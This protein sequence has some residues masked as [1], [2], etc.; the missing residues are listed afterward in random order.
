M[1]AREAQGARDLCGLL[2]EKGVLD[3]AEARECREESEVAMG[4][5]QAE[6][7]AGVLYRFGEGLQLRDRDGRIEVLVGNRIQGR[8]TY[9]DPVGG[10][11][12]SAFAVRRFKTF[13]RGAFYR[14]WLHFKLQVNWVGARAANGERLPDL[15]DALLEVA[16]W[17]AAAVGAGQFKVPFNR[18]ELT[19]SGAQQFVDRAITNDR[20]A[21]DRDQGVTVHGK[22]VGQNGAAVEYAVAVL[23]GS[24]KNRANNRTEPLVAGRAQWLPLGPLAYSESDVAFTETARLALGVAFARQPVQLSSDARRPALMRLTADAHFQWRGLSVAGDLFLEEPE[25][26]GRAGTPGAL[27]QAGWFLVPGRLEVAGRYAVYNPPGEK[28]RR[29]EARGGINWFFSGHSLKLQVDAGAVT[30]EEVGASR[31][32]STDARLQV[33]VIF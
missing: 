22:L 15:E 13:A 9:A 7:S 21:F 3:S 24:G 26:R 16:R 11:A 14:P 18:Q 19:S 8:Y 31:L 17:P 5:G 10:R 4:K 20:F 33:Q 27:V 6:R 29:E 23:N 12:T 28:N 32:G 2:Q 25:G 30:G 1:L